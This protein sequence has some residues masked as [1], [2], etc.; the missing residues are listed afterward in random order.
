[1]KFLSPACLTVRNIFL[2]LLVFRAFSAVAQNTFTDGLSWVSSSAMTSAQS[3][4]YSS[5]YCQD[6]HYTISTTSVLGFQYTPNAINGSGVLMPGNAGNGNAMVVTI[7]FNVPVS[8]FGMRVL[9][10]DED[11]Q[12]DAGAAEEYLT[13]FSTPPASVAPISGL[14][15]VFLS[16]NTV[17]PDDGDPGNANGNAAGWIWWSGQ[18]TSVTF[19]YQRYNNQYEYVLDSLHF[20]CPCPTPI[21]HISDAVMCPQGSYQLNASTP[22]ATYLWSNGSTNN[23]ITATAPGTYWV[24]VWRE[25]CLESDTAV[26]SII[27]TPPF[28]LG[29]DSTICEG[30]MVTLTAGPQFPSVMW[31]NGTTAPSFSASLQGNYTGEATYS[32]CTLRDTFQLTVNAYPHVDLGNDT[33]LCE[34]Q[35]VLLKA[36]NGY[37]YLWSNGSTGPAINVSADGTYWVDVSN[38]SCMASDTITVQFDPL[39]PNPL[40]SDT[41]ICQMTLTV[42]SDAAYEWFNGSQELSV[43]VSEAGD[44]WVESQLNGCL[45]SD[46]LHV[47]E[48]PAVNASFSYD[49]LVV[50]CE[51]KSGLIGPV[52]SSELV[53]V[54]WDDGTAALAINVDEPGVHAFTVSTPCES[55]T[56]TI[57]VEEEKCFCNVWVPNA[58]TPD[59]NTVNE[60]FAAKYDCALDRFEL[61]VFDRWGSIVFSATDPDAS[62]DGTFNGLPVPDGVYVYKVI[63][64]SAQMETYEEVTGHVSVLR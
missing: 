58:F 44:Y 38:G 4:V 32:G 20:E 9:D 22:N 39:P 27:Q 21:D 42:A 45:R 16:G 3:P 36:P 35:H 46:T 50:I 13:G 49:S 1:M 15:P 19:T 63:Y 64:A 33:T 24:N 18:V 37:S 62:W 6:I 26:I 30:E 55:V 41:I 7:T 57:R 40:P 53:S 25:S 43:V 52:V 56:H 51:G 5:A 29:P 14:N 59:N 2:L 28:D 31:Q 60:G 8:N 10:L 12:H 54:T 47:G 48:Y 17:T 23:G 34:G 11:N 61:L